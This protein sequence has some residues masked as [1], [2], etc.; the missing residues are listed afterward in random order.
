MSQNFL[1]ALE[2]LVEHIS[3]T[4]PNECAPEEYPTC[5]EISFRSNI[6]LS[7]CETNLENKNRIKSGKSCLF[8]LDK[9]VTNNDKLEISLFKKKIEKCKFLIGSTDIAIKSMFDKVIENFKKINSKIIDNNAIS[10]DNKKQTDQESSGFVKGKEDFIP[11]SEVIKRL[12]PLF[13]AKGRQ[14]GSIII[15]LRLSCIGPI[16]TSTFTICDTKSNKIPQDNSCLKDFSNIQKSGKKHTKMKNQNKSCS[17]QSLSIVSL[18][19][20]NNKMVTSKRNLKFIY[21]NFS[22]F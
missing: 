15:F 22:L 12:L 3:I 11:A 4:R 18:V 21:T 13:D 2:C 16:V 14:S 9:P 8:A 5:V 6:F 1:Y 17:E 19:S 20:C 7:V 10:K